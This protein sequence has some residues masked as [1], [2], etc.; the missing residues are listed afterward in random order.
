[1]IEPLKTESEAID[2][3]SKA[4]CIVDLIKELML[5]EDSKRYSETSLGTIAQI[6]IDMMQEV[7]CFM[8]SDHD[9]ASA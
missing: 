8:E 3:L 4:Q 9:K 2:M 6:A 7:I 5:N 1:M